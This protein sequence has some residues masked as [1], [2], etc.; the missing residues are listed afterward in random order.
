MLL[1][2]MINECF[3]NKKSLCVLFNSTDKNGE[4]NTP[5]CPTICLP[6]GAWQFG[7]L[8]VTYI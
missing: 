8:G 1:L 4:Y 7:A 3:K 2:V 5:L 6:Y